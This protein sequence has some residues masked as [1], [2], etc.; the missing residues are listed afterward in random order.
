MGIGDEMV[1]EI[2]PDGKVVEIKDPQL[3]TVKKLLREKIA[4]L[5]AENEWLIKTLTAWKEKLRDGETAIQWFSE[6]TGEW[7]DEILHMCNW[8]TGIMR[9]VKE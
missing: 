6:S 5:E 2:L 4:V 7:N 8:G 1:L 3:D 9:R